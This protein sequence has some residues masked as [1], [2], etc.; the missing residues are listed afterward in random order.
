MGLPCPPAAPSPC[1]RR[2]AGLPC[3]R[4]TAT[5]LSAGSG[6]VVRTHYFA[7]DGR[8]RP[9]KTPGCTAV[10]PRLL[11]R[12]PWPAAATRDE[13]R[14]MPGQARLSLVRQSPLLRG[15]FSFQDEGAGSSPARPT[16]PVLTCGNARRWPPSIA[17]ASVRRLRTAVRERIPVTA[18]LRRSGREWNGKLTVK[19]YGKRLMRGQRRLTSIW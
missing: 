7:P 14:G 4:A 15:R 18:A 1:R 9:G 13:N 2:V 3:P 10:S 6:G 17:V 16:T 12:P 11:I 8:Q 19:C 5:H